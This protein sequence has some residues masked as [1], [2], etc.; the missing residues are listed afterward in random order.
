M[1]SFG[2][3]TFGTGLK[4]TEMITIV[5]YKA[6][7]LRSVAKAFE[8]LGAE[9]RVSA[10]PEDILNA[11][12]LVLP[13][14]GAF[15]DG[16]K[17][18]RDS[19]LLEPLRKA[20]LSDKKP[21]LGVC[22]GMQ[23]F[24]ES[25]EEGGLHKGLGWIEGRVKKLEPGISSLKVPH[26]GWNSVAP[27]EEAILF[28]NIQ[29]NPSFYFVHSYAVDCKNADD[30]AATCNYGNDFTVAIQKENLFGLQFHP[31]KSQKDGL[32]VLEN[33]ISL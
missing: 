16:M 23:L 6:G 15:G 3:R 22:L 1:K 21:I 18:L 9:A 11:E 27:K 17:N 20:V 12:K 19:L 24:A 14:V 13:G 4:L 5:D 25:S 8:F 28:R 33:F 31:E 7:N 32:R 2:T 10:L 30:V 26:V 29:P